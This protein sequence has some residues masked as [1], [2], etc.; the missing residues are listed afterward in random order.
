MNADQSIPNIVGGNTKL[1]PETA[2]TLTAGV[3]IQPVFAPRLTF[4]VDFYNV[5][6]ANAI[7]APS[8]QSVADECVDL[9]TINNPFCAATLRTADK[10]KPGAITQVTAQEINVASFKTDGL[11]FTLTL[12]PRPCGYIQERCRDARYSPDRLQT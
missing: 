4:S 1:T 11:D 9:S 10:P 7:E 12:P 8:A 5:T 2:R 6:I 3:V